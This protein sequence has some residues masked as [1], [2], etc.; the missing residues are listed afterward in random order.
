[1][2]PEEAFLEDILEHPDDEAPRLIYADWLDDHG[3]PERAE[4]IRAECELERIEAYS[5][6]WRQLSERQLTL[7]KANKKKWTH[8]LRGLISS[9]FFRRGF[10]ET[11]TLSAQQFAQN[12][13]TIF[14][15][16]P[17]RQIHFNRIWGG[18]T[19]PELIAGREELSRVEGLDFSH[20][21]LRD[22]GLRIILQSPHL[23]NLT[24]LVLSRSGV[25]Q[26]GVRELASSQRLNDLTTLHLEAN[27]LGEGGIRN[28]LT[29]PHLTKLHTLNLNGNGIGDEGVRA[30][31]R[32]PL[33]KELNVLGLEDFFTTPITDAGFKE[34]VESPHLHRL[35]NLNFAGGQISDASVE[36]LS[37]AAAF[38]Q[39]RQLNLAREALRR[40][41]VRV[42]D[43]GARALAV[44][45]GLAK[46][47][48]LNLAN[49]YLTDAGAAALAESPH[50]GN[51]GHLNLKG[52]AI[53]ANMQ[54]TL[55]KRFGVGVCTFSKS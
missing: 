23:P 22:E 53:S 42:T 8:S 12:A 49:N 11:V 26:A 34:L 47:H 21:L 32:S 15:R 14:Q 13:A 3:Q 24:S 10:V 54:K 46:L 19:E 38:P 39:L 18:I 45:P 41:N 25:T 29:S 37:H 43:A 31:A 17:V 7:I 51:L 36:R 48:W 2:T 16:A 33:L 27:N 20:S 1:M 4:Y 35:T 5:P 44:S 6:R 55:R 28:L 9:C 40:P 50:L 30:L 52:N